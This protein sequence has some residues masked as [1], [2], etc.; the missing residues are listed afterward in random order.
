MPGVFTHPTSGNFA[1]PVGVTDRCKTRRCTA[2]DEFGVVA[3]RLRERAFVNARDRPNSPPRAKKR[4]SAQPSHC[5]GLAMVFGFGSGSKRRRDDTEGAGGKTKARKRSRALTFSAKEQERLADARIVMEGETGAAA[6]AR[7]HELLVGAKQSYTSNSC[8]VMAHLAHRIL[9]ERNSQD[10]FSAKRPAHLTPADVLRVLVDYQAVVLEEP[11]AVS[12]RSRRIPRQKI[13]AGYPDLIGPLIIGDTM[14][15]F[16]GRSFLPGTTHQVLQYGG[17]LRHLPLPAAGK[18]VVWT[19]D[20]FAKA[21][22]KAVVVD[23]KNNH[24][25]NNTPQWHSQMILGVT[26]D[27]DF[28]ICLQTWTGSELTLVPRLSTEELREKV[29]SVLEKQKRPQIDLNKALGTVGRLWA[30]S[31]PNMMGDGPIDLRGAIDRLNVPA[32]GAPVTPSGAAP[33]PSALKRLASM[34]PTGLLK[35]VLK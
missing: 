12:H 3:A 28:W 20:S 30:V 6:L 19:P 4:I 29:R 16:F 15:L 27:E 33:P 17:V 11:K 23:A 24:C 26:R 31:I 35:S 7:T 10:R 34:V 5:R 32:M 8:A 14:P 13:K 18:M 1:T 21:F 9:L 2:I 22:A 25:V